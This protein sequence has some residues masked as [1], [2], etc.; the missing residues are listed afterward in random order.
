MT[1]VMSGS[2]QGAAQGAASGMSIGWFGKLPSHGD[3]LQRRVPESFLNKWDAWLQECIAQS[4]AHLGDAWLDTYLTSPVWRF[5]LSQGVVGSSS[6]AG[7]VLPS[8]DRVGRYFPLTIFAELPAD[9][10]AIAVAIHGREW[11]KTVE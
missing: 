2:L 8:V 3:F 4:R 7:I 1:A 5:F 6:F 11:L 10:S 9:L